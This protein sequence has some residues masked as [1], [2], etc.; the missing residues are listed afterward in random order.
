MMHCMTAGGLL[1]DA[2]GRVQDSV[3][4]AVEGLDADQLAARL[5]PDANPISWLIWHLTRVQDDHVAAAFGTAEVWSTRSW[6][7]RLGMPEHTREIGYGQTPAQVEAVASAICGM[8]SPGKLLAEY[9]D[10]VYEQ[11]ISLVSGLTD[12]DLE[13]V[14]DERWTPPVTLGVRLVSVIGDDLQHAGQANYV[15]GILLRRT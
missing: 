1:T 15:R 10:A 13:R 7:P 9:H 4:S 2:F 5:D 8:P 6:G 11:T 12:A 3:N 14:V